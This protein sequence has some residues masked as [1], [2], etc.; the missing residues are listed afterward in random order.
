MEP[1]DITFDE[2][3][4]ELDKVTHEYGHSPESSYS[5]ETGQECWREY[6]EDGYSPEE[7]YREDISNA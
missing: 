4:L 2:W 7:A 3:L 5:K 6:Y 1:D